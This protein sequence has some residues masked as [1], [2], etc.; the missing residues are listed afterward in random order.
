M[1]IDFLSS[2]IVIIP[3]AVIVWFI[4]SITRFAGTDKG[5]TKE[6]AKRKRRLKIASGIFVAVGIAFAIVVSILYK[7]LENFT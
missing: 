3:L 6:Y 5:D 1:V 7:A 4:Y 2:L